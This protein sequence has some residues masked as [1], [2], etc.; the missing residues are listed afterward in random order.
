[1]KSTNESLESTIRN[2]LSLFEKLQL[3]VEKFNNIL[4]SP[5]LWVHGARV[6][7]ENGLFP[8]QYFSNRAKNYF[9]KLNSKPNHIIIPYKEQ[10]DHLGLIKDLKLDKEQQTASVDEIKNLLEKTKKI[11]LM[12]L[13]NYR[14]L[15]ILLLESSPILLR[16]WPN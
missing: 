12:L 16:H 1:L 7:Y 11:I 5:Q 13:K 8:I 14:E 15:R 3:A 9:Q 2:S 10:M 4:S 6:N